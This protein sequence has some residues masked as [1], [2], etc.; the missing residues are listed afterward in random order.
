MATTIRKVDAKAN[1][2]KAEATTTKN[3]N[4]KKQKK[5][6]IEPRRRSAIRPEGAD[7]RKVSAVKRQLFSSSSS[8]SSSSS[9]AG[10]SWKRANRFSANQRTA[11]R[12]ASHRSERGF[13]E[14]CYRVFLFVVVVVVVV[15]SGR[16][17]GGGWRRAERLSFLGNAAVVRRL[18]VG[19]SPTLC[20]LV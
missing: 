6:P 1:R 7:D 5:T 12:E 3:N 20:P 18:V 15:G 2:A 19:A 17:I 11:E 14:F 4:K 9:Y 16:V 8:S 10:V 13:T